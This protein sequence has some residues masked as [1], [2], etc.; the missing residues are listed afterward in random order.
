LAGYF[1]TLS[2]NILLSTDKKNR[3]NINRLASCNISM[4]AEDLPNEAGNASELEP[5]VHKQRIVPS[6]LNYYDDPGDGSPP[7]PVVVGG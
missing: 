2:S 3:E 7:T 4:A 6:S 1:I 5:K